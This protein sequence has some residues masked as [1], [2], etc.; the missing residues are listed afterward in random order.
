MPLTK[1]PP[2]WP[3]GIRGRTNPTENAVNKSQGELKIIGMATIS[4]EAFDNMK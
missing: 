3:K 2:G 4:K 1:P